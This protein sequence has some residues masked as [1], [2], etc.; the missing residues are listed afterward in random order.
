[1]TI[2]VWVLLFFAL[3]TLVLLVISVG[4]YRL[5]RIFTGRSP[6]RDYAF[7]DVD[8]SE[9]HRRASRAHLNCVENL[10]IYGAIVLAVVVSGLRSPLLDKLAIT[11]LAAR[12]VQ[13]LIQ[14]S[15]RQTGRVTMVRFSFFVVQL[16]CMIWM[17]MLVI[18]HQI[19]I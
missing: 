8:Q 1:M 19:L 14:L 18:Q 9:W 15:F 2:P 6:V 16:V 5:W 10:P 11:F 13:S 3:W 12:I 7:P 17:G 4:V